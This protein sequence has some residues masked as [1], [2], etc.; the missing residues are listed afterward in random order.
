MTSC[1]ATRAN[2]CVSSFFLAHYIVSEA[3]VRERRNTEKVLHMQRSQQ[4]AD[5]DVNAHNCFVRNGD[6]EF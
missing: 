1:G 6:G 2:R 5:D 4:D 3:L